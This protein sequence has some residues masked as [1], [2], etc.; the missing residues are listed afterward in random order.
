MSVE[1]AEPA[2]RPRL[3]GVSHAL[4]SLAAVPAGGWLIA[5]APNTGSRVAT[6]AY[7]VTMI[8]M[9]AVSATY[10]RFRWPPGQRRVIKAVDHMA[11]FG[12][13][14]G[15]YGPLGVLRLSPPAA[16]TWLGALWVGAVVG[17][18]VKFR[19]LD[20]LGGPADLLYGVLSG[21]VLLLLPA[22]GQRLEPAE[23]ALLLGGLACYGLSSACLMTRRPYA[24]PATFGYHE[25]AHL[26]VVGGAAIHIAFYAML[27]R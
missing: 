3:K 23:L 7:V 18:L 6:V 8:T 1:V 15:S 9:F 17:S 21:S 14:A 25:C 12:F 10:H 5:Q 11:I 22:L 26:W 13:I 16:A 24:W 20:R 4:A 19:T 27:F 2:P